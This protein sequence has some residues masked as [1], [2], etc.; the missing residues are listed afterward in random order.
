[1]G[2]DLEKQ[3]YDLATEREKFQ[4]EITKLINS[5][6]DLREQ[7]NENKGLLEE[8]Q[9]EVEYYK[10]REEEGTIEFEAKHRRRASGTILA[11]LLSETKMEVEGKYQ[12]KEN[13]QPPSTLVKNVSSSRSP[14]NS[15]QYFLLA[16][17]A[18][19]ISCTM[20]PSNGSAVACRL[21]NEDEL[22][23]QLLKEKV[24]FCNWFE[25]I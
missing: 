11:E 8:A 13:K 12:E 20:K 17:S 9:S 19:R 15:K 6:T 14:P 18:V 25:C 3:I 24:P 1:M 21:V 22:Y 10:Q 16:V 23:Q 5:E 7:L 4:Y 2:K